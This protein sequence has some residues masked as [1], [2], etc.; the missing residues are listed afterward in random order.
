VSSPEKL[1]LHQLYDCNCPDC[2]GYTDKLVISE[3]ENDDLQKAFNKAARWIFSQKKADIQ[4]DDLN[5]NSV[6]P[7]LNNIH[8]ILQDGYKKGIS[9]SVPYILK[10]DLSEN[11]YVFS[12]AK[13]YSELKELSGLLLDS[14]GNI[15]PF[16]KFW[17]DVQSI[18]PEY[19]SNYLEAEYI[20][21]TQSAQMASRW[22]EYEADGDR[23]NL[24]Y[25]TAGD[26]RVRES[27]QLLH[28]ITLPP[29]DPFWNEYYPPNGWRCRCTAVQ[30]LRQDYKKSDSDQSQHLGSDATTG[31]N[32]IFRFNPGKQ[33]VIFPDN[34]PYL[35]RLKNQYKEVLRRKFEEINEIRTKDDVVSVINEIDKEKKWFERG[36]KNLDVTRKRTANGSTDMNGKILLTKDRL[37]NT[38]SGINKLNKSGEITVDEADSI[39]TFWHEITHNRSKPGN[40]F[41]TRLQTRYMELANEFVARNTLDEFYSAFGS[42][43]QHPEFMTNRASTGYNTMVRNYQQI[44]G[45]TGLNNKKVVEKVKTHLFNK[46]YTEQKTG[47]TNALDGAKKLDGKKLGKEQI[48]TLV[49]MCDQYEEKDF[50]RKLDEFI[51]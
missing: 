21:A 12:G 30:V 34:H 26:D 32:K 3:T 28:N 38:I 9:H 39:A 16:N 31:K 27:H 25:R 29:S 8:T 49:R 22:N 14:D 43:V 5:E 13:T 37:E 18:Y 17:Q 23:Y 47:L 42:K 41:T 48:G 46:P 6:Q 36:F 2:G 19:N 10:R 4:P 35:K 45:K 51:R 50:V 7:L 40:M 1:S 24:Q 15:K 33:H 20:F 44:I 11:I